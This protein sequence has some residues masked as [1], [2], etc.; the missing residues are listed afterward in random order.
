MANKGDYVCEECGPG[1]HDFENCPVKAKTTNL[2]SI[3]P[4][5]IETMNLQTESKHKPKENFP[6][7]TV[8][9]VRFQE[10]TQL[11]WDTIKEIEGE[12]KIEIAPKKEIQVYQRCPKNMEPK[13]L[14]LPTT[15]TNFNDDD[16]IR[17]MLEWSEQMNIAIPLKS[18]LEVWLKK[19]PT[20][21]LE[22]MP[23]LATHIDEDPKVPMH[24]F[25]R[26]ISL[27]P[28]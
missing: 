6:I 23:R 21:V 25:N 10:A 28:L 13:H 22:K 20:Q 26:I 14:Q 24:V 18:L 3:I 11:I 17:L 4:D 19:P 2:V 12:N 15:Q 5:Q 7:P 9:K 1:D 16:K 8:E 27:K